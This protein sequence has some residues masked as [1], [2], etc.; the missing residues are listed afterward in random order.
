MRFEVKPWVI[1]LAVAAAIIIGVL[2]SQGWF[3]VEAFLAVIGSW[4]TD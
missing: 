3:D 2:A 4:W 1:M